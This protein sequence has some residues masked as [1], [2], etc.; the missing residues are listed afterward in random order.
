VERAAG[1]EPAASWLEARY[2]AI[3]VLPA[4]R[5]LVF[6]DMILVWVAG[7]E[8]AAARIRNGMSTWLTYTQMRE[9]ATAH[10]GAGSGS[11]FFWSAKVDI[12]VLL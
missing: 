9:E 10:G 5:M 8:P 7:F 2:L 11:G 6:V 1:I 12:V 4:G 3:E